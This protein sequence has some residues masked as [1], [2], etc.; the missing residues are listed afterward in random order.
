VLKDDIQ[1]AFGVASGWM[2]GVT[3]V[4]GIVELVEMYEQDGLVRVQSSSDKVS[5]S[6]IFI[7]IPISTV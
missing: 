5:V 4:I 1:G 2:M 3:I 6:I 7:S